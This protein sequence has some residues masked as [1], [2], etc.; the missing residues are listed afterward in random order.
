[1]EET[2]WRLW[3]TES[4][5]VKGLLHKIYLN[6][7][8]DIWSLWA[9]CRCQS[10]GCFDC[11]LSWLL[12]G[13]ASPGLGEEYVTGHHSR[14]RHLQIEDNSM[15]WRVKA[16]RR[17]LSSGFPQTLQNMTMLILSVLI[18]HSQPFAENVGKCRLSTLDTEFLDVN[19]KGTDLIKFR[20]KVCHIIPWLCAI[21]SCSM[22][23][24]WP[25]SLSRFFRNS[26]LYGNPVLSEHAFIQMLETCVKSWICT[27]KLQS[28]YKIFLFGTRFYV[29]IYKLYIAEGFLKKSWPLRYLWSQYFCQTEDVCPKMLKRNAFHFHRDSGSPLQWFV[30][31]DE[32]I[33]LKHSFGCKPTTCTF[34]NLKWYILSHHKRGQGL[35]TSRYP[36]AMGLE[37]QFTLDSMF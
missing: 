16:C 32:G 10:G 34:T 8:T 37:W 31:C 27:V 18:F 26:S 11:G 28:I 3:N 6:W 2:T 19:K 20:G 12:D 4:N 1:M 21:S 22:T 25:L 5:E 7:Y 9:F 33:V 23:F 13:G 15:S 30:F 29:Y 17:V 35:G 24:P 36:E 14:G